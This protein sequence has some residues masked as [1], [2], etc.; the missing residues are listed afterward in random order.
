NGALD[1]ARHYLAIAAR[2]PSPTD[3]SAAYVNLG[4]IEMREGHAA[5]GRGAFELARATAP[6]EPLPYVYLS[7]WQ[8][9]AGHPDSARAVLQRGLA[10]RRLKRRIESEMAALAKPGSAL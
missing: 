7:R 9:A 8:T 6:E 1:A 5:A 4:M 2:A 10:E 3:R